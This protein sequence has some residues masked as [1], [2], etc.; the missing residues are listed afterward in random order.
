MVFCH[1]TSSLGLGCFDDH[2]NKLPL[3]FTQI[4]AKQ[5]DTKAMQRIKIYHIQLLNG[6]LEST[7]LHRR[8]KCLISEY[9]IVLMKDKCH[10]CYL[11][12]DLDEVQSSFFSVIRQ[13]NKQTSQ[14][15]EESFLWRLWWSLSQW[16]VFTPHDIFKRKFRFRAEVV[17]HVACLGVR[18]GFLTSEAGLCHSVAANN[19]MA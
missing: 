11:L 13:S 3:L 4:K 17:T 2:H 19:Q 6:H 8:P 15:D 18:E 7:D 9:Y 12:Y 14:T 1:C 10:L 16:P 5:L